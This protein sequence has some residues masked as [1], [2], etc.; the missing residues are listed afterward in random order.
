MS[1]NWAMHVFFVFSAGIGLF[2]IWALTLANKKNG[3]NDNKNGT[4]KDNGES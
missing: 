3:N 4:L 1:G 2:A